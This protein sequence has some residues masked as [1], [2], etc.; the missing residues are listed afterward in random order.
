[1][2]PVLAKQIALGDVDPITRLPMNDI[3]PAFV[4]RVLKPPP[5]VVNSASQSVKNKGV[6]P[7]SLTPEDILSVFG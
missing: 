2:D 5:L 7:A 1:M 3:Y 4:P 6:E